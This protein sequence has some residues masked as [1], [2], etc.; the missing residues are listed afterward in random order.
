MGRKPRIWSESGFYHVVTRGNNR[1]RVFRDEEDRSRYLKMVAVA[2]V[3]KGMGLYHYCLMT[4]HV[5]LLVGCKKPE[6]L[7]C[8]MHEVQRRYWFWYRKKYRHSGHLW[9]GR[10]HS[11]AIETESYLLECGRYIE[12]NPLQ[13]GMV[14]KL[15]TYEW[16]SY[17]WYAYGKQRDIVLVPSPGY[18]SMGRRS[19]ERQKAYQ[20][21][22][23]TNR[24]YDDAMKGIMK[25]VLVRTN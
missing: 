9:Q 12:R 14:E 21:Y 3:R 8:G 6:D 25:G 13:A 4:N 16:S 18:L 10:F 24:P 22:V 2:F 15:E 23:A 19:Q 1:W 11:F 20:T 7:S 17:L 5:H